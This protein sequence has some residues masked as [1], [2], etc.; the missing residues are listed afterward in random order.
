MFFSG[1]FYKAS[2]LEVCLGYDE[3][4]TCTVNSCQVTR[5]KNKVEFHHSFSPGGSVIKIVY[6]PKDKSVRAGEPPVSSILLI[7][8]SQLLE[9]YK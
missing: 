3:L 7:E 4:D 6:R 9:L 8:M 5:L 2:T 1:F